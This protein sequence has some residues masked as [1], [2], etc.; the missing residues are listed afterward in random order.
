MGA[1]PHR[2]AVCNSVATDAWLTLQAAIGLYS[3]CGF[4]DV[5]EQ[6]AP[7]MDGPAQLK[8]GELS[9]CRHAAAGCF[10]QE[11]EMCPSVMVLACRSN[12]IA[13]GQTAALVPDLT[14]N[15]FAH[16]SDFL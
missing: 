10:M 3:K 16:I 14:E 12:Q 9:R 2:W 1:F 15:N 6:L 11:A 8:I 13:Q 7:S 5:T 4:Q